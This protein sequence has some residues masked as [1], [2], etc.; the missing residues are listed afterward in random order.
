MTIRLIAMATTSKKQV[1]DLVW[2]SV[3][4]DGTSLG[5]RDLRVGGSTDVNDTRRGKFS[6]FELGREGKA[7]QEM[8]HSV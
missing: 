1:H 4:P 2:T 7:N 8:I 5:H 3:T 6:K